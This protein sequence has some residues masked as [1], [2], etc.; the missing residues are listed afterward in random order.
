LEVEA[1]FNL[2]HNN[3]ENNFLLIAGF[4]GDRN[5]MVVS[6][7]DNEIGFAGDTAVAVQMQENFLY[8]NKPTSGN[9]LTFSI[10]GGHIS[11]K[12]TEAG[13]LEGAGL[14]LKNPLRSGSEMASSN[15]VINGQINGVEFVN[16]ATDV[17]FLHDRGPG[18]G[19]QTVLQMRGNRHVD[20]LGGMRQLLV[21]DNPPES[22]FK[23][24]GTQT[25]FDEQNLNFDS[26]GLEGHFTR[27]DDDI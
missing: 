19:N 13:E 21:A 6:L 15:N 7:I 27:E 2:I 16:T 25:S 17:V 11:G 12:T 4:G 20:D 14:T 22:E 9:S 1:S 8:E 3:T 5:D 10:S 23:V 26:A 18:Q 24:V